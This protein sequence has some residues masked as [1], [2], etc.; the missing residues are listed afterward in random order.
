MLLCMSTIGS[1]FEKSYSSAEKRME[2][3]KFGSAISKLVKLVED[4]K[5]S[6]AERGAGGR[7]AVEG[8]CGRRQRS[9]GVESP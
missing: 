4:R 5:A 2:K 7:T 1:E 6:D 8:V 9:P 3:G